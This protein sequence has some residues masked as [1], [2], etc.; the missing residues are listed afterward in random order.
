M[1][2]TY[3][4]VQQ[5]CVAII[6]C[7]LL[8]CLIYPTSTEGSNGKLRT[9]YYTGRS[10]YR[11]LSSLYHFDR[12]FYGVCRFHYVKPGTWYVIT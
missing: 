12:A 8:V 10:A 4:H 7:V 2:L 9:R 6:P 1:M 11:P 5:Q 3:E